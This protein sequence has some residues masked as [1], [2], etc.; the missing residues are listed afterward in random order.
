ML[1]L[2]RAVS[3]I[4]DYTKGISSHKRQRITTIFSLDCAGF[5]KKSACWCVVTHILIPCLI[6]MQSSNRNHTHLCRPHV[7]SLYWIST[8]V[9]S[10]FYYQEVRHNAISGQLSSTLHKYSRTSPLSESWIPLSVSTCFL[11]VP[12]AYQV[13]VPDWRTNWLVSGEV[14]SGCC[15]PVAHRIRLA[16][17][18]RL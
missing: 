1:Q 8:G 16:F 10:S 6:Y 9:L 15:S 3:N 18:E 17:G 7:E 13:S 2:R 14:G 5:S 4:L 12:T 11:V